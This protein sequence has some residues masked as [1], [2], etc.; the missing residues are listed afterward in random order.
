MAERPGPAEALAPRAVHHDRRVPTGRD[1]D[2]RR[3]PGPGRSRAGR[4]GAAAAAAA[5]L[6]AGCHG[7]AA[8]RPVAGAGSSVGAPAE[9]APADERSTALQRLLDARAAAVLAHD[10]DGVLALVDPGAAAFR[11]RQE[12]T[13]LG[14][15]RVP[16]AAWSY[17]VVGEGPRLA[18]DRRA[19]L[20][21]SAWVADVR[22][23]YRVDGVDV[24][25]QQRQRSF[26]VVERGGVWLLAD[27]ADGPSRPDV[28]DLGAVDV[29][30]GSRTLVVGTAPRPV[31]E[32]QAALGDA[33]A[34]RVDAVWGTAWPRTTVVVVPDDADQLVRLLGRE[35]AAGLDQVAA[36]TTGADRSSGAPGAAGAV[37]RV[38]VNPAALDVLGELGREVVLT[39]E[40][41]HVAVRA[42]AAADPPPW[43]SEGFAELVAYEG[44][45][46]GPDVAAADLLAEVRAGRGPVALP[47]AA[48][49]DPAVGTVA[50]AYSAAWLAVRTVDLRHGRAALLELVRAASGRAAGAGDPGA[51]DPDARDMGAGDSGVGDT[52]AEEGDGLR[53]APLPLAD[54]VPRVLGVDLDVLTAQWREDMAALAGAGAPEATATSGDGG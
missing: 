23:R 4:A 41:T 2:S 15:A 53:V 45:G 31:L 52:D 11:E 54:A 46:L 24:V 36:L 19:A 51:G 27:D 30:R 34:E 47:S 50:P 21:G 14:L 6:L 44:A 10:V 37:D 17:E 25:D 43:L 42:G 12:R 16:L 29:V 20:G 5:L 40:T 7:P 38:V 22:L 1:Q 49:F 26:T 8:E 48:D 32:Q 39:H 33:A 9:A 13:V 3:R 28:W 18:E 35:D